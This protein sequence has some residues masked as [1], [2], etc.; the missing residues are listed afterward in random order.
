MTNLTIDDRAKRSVTT[1]WGRYLLDKST[2]LFAGNFHGLLFADH[3]QGLLVS[4]HFKEPL[5]AGRLAP[6]IERTRGAC[7][8]MHIYRGMGRM[9]H[10]DRCWKRSTASP[11]SP[12]SEVMSDGAVVLR[13]RQDDSNAALLVVR[14]WSVCLAPPAILISFR[15]QCIPNLI[16]QYT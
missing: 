7:L 14:C 13:D 10:F 9:Q 4:G 3:L 16:T 5:F 1:Q 11:S 8:F 15:G 12:S 6:D 2:P